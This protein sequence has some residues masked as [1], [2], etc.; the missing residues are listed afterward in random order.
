[1]SGCHK[2]SVRLIVAL[3]KIGCTLLRVCLTTFGKELHICGNSH[4]HNYA[5][6]TSGDV[7]LQGT[8]QAIGSSEGRNLY[9]PG[10]Q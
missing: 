5:E 8:I 6:R 4:A 2:H 7:Q 3:S 1:M 10:F 9:D